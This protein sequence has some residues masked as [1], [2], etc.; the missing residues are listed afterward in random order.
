MKALPGQGLVLTS[1]GVWGKAAVSGGMTAGAEAVG[2]GLLPG[3]GLAVG[4]PE[5]AGEPDGLDPGLVAGD[6]L[7]GATLAALPRSVSVEAD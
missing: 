3:A 6:E 5:G 7:A 2:W 4:E 1:V